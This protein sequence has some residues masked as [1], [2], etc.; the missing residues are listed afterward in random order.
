M[1]GERGEEATNSI[2]RLKQKT[3]FPAAT[4]R[5]D[6]LSL[7]FIQREGNVQYRSGF[8]YRQRL[9]LSLLQM[10]TQI[11]RRNEPTNSVGRVDSG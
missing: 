10:S 2:M 8:E 11:L 6:L 4:P 5:S 7:T 1:T 9:K 3:N